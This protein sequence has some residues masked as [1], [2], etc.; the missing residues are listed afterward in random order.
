[1][2]KNYIDQKACP[3]CKY[4]LRLYDCSFYCNQDNAYDKSLDL[5][6]DDDIIKIWDWEDSHRVSWFGICDEYSDKI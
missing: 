1:M 6:D 2:R 4:C 5:F 3:T